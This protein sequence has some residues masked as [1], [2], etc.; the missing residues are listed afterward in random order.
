MF[1]IALEQSPTS[2]LLF[3][4]YQYV[5]MPT[6]GRTDYGRRGA[7]IWLRSWLD[8]GMWCRDTIPHTPTPFVSVEDAKAEL[9]SMRL[10]R[11]EVVGDRLIIVNATTGETME[12]AGA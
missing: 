5:A 8:R 12:G 4:G 7:P 1:S 2:R 10:T 6:D 3:C 11:P 9:D